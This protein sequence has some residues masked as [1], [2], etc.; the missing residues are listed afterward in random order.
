MDFLSLQR[1]RQIPDTP[2]DIIVLNSVAFIGRSVELLSGYQHV[3]QY[4]NHDS[5]GHAA[6]EKLKQAGIQA[7]D[8]GGFYR[9]HNDIN[10][11]LKAC[12]KE[13]QQQRQSQQEQWQGRGIGR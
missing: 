5:A 10:D 11:Y 7:T 13:E 1:L 9:G 4:L 6:A 12:L 3:Y 8:S 2:T